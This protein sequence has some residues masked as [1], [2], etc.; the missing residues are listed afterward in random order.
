MCRLSFNC[1]SI[2]ETYAC[3]SCSCVVIGVGPLG[4]TFVN[5]F[6]TICCS[7]IRLPDCARLKY[8]GNPCCGTFNREN[9]VGSRNRAVNSVWKIKQSFNSSQR[10]TLSIDCSWF[11][12][13]MWA[14]RT[15][16]AELLS[17]IQTRNGKESLCEWNAFIIPMENP[18]FLKYWIWSGC[19]GGGALTCGCAGRFVAN[20]VCDVELNGSKL[21]K[22]GFIP[23]MVL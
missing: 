10:V 9:R 5:K 20:E 13:T 3:R 7:S 22:F 4:I 19:I 11:P 6:R 21:L 15:P 23:L 2:D 14:S 17:S 16:I 18:W 8:C 1:D 12:R